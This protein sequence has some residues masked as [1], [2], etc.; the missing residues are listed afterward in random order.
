HRHDFNIVADVTAI[1][2]NPVFF[3]TV[4]GYAMQTFVV[5]GYSSFGE[6]FLEEADGITASKSSLLFGVITFVAGVSGTAF[7]GLLL[8]QYSKSLISNSES[9]PEIVCPDPTTALLAE[10]VIPERRSRILDA[11]RTVAAL[12]I[13]SAAA[14]IVW[15]YRELCFIDILLLDFTLLCI[16]FYLAE[17]TYFPLWSIPY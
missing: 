12:R 6:S 7:G 5:G 11:A 8:D 9:C 17:S 4:F 2:S 13:I 16:I 1:L 10:G 14:W 3:W 15:R